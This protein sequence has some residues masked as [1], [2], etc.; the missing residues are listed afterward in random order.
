MNTTTQTP[1]SNN[2]RHTIDTFANE[3]NSMRIKIRLND[4]C[5]NG[6]QDFAITAD[7]F[8]KGKPKIDKYIMMCGCCHDEIIAAHPELKIFVDLHLCDYKGIPMYAVENGYYHLRNGFNNTP[9]DSSKFKIEFC[10]YYRVTIR[11]FEVLNTSENKTQYA[12]NIKKLHILDQWENQAREAIS[13]LEG[14]TGKQFLIDSKR[15]QFN[16]PTP[17][18]VEEENEKQESGYYTPEAKL[19][20]ATAEIDKLQDEL[21][22]EEELKL[23]AVLTEY[24]IKK[25]V[26]SIGGTAA[27]NNCIYYTHTKQIAFNWRDSDPIS[28]EL[29]SKLKL[30]LILPDGVTFENKKK[31]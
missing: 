8:E 25:Q 14:L 9:S 15:T 26:L 31:G 21:S 7:I 24:N 6:H 19:I 1:A 20:R 3:G 29:I 5:G 12:L 10:E 18:Q 16:E 2:L 27:L 4:E 11:Q 17:E 23:N 30:E 13:I 28:D 22:N